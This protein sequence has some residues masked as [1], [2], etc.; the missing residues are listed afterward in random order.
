MNNPELDIL[1]QIVGP[2]LLRRIKD[3]LGGTKVYI[4]KDV[5]ERRN[6]D[7]LTD[8]N[9]GRGL[10][11]NQ[12]VLKYKLSYP[13]IRSIVRPYRQIPKTQSLDTVS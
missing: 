1:L 13:Q 2:E 4:P 8:Y 10:S 11:L 12:L 7:I 3:E 5:K 9:D 6:A